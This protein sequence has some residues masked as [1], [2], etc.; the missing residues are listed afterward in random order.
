MRGK[1]YLSLGNISMGIAGSHRSTTPSSS[2]YLGMRV[3]TVD[4]VEF[5]RRIE[6]GIFDPAE[7]AKAMAWVKEN[8]QEGKDYNAPDMQL[9]RRAQGTRPGSGPSRWP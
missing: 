7:F 9:S 5:V 1:S 2:D 4:M 6:R 8:C 3:E